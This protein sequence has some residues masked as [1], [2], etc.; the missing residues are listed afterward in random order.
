[1]KLL[2]GAVVGAA[3]TLASSSATAQKNGA[4]STEETAA[5]DAAPA[6]PQPVPPT[7]P[8]QPTQPVQANPASSQ[9][10]ADSGKATNADRTALNLLGELEQIQSS[11]NP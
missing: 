4:L 1:M 9:A 7:Q 2:L 8:P 11:H 6:E 5:P 3:L 10:L